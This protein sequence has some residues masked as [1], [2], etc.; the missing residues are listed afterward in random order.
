MTVQGAA[1]NGDL[2]A[3]FEEPSISFPTV[4]KVN[5][6]FSGG[7]ATGTYTHS[8]PAYGVISDEPS[9]Y[10]FRL[11]H[12]G[13]SALTLKSVSLVEESTLPPEVRTAVKV[14][15]MQDPLGAVALSGE[16]LEAEVRLENATFKD[17]GVVRITDAG[18]EEISHVTI[19]P[20]GASSTAATVELPDL[21]A[22][23]YQ[24]TGGV[25]SAQGRQIPYILSVVPGETGISVK[26]FIG[27]H[28]YSKDKRHMNTQALLGIH[29]ARCFEMPWYQVEETAA[30]YVFPV[31]VVDEYLAAGIEPMVLLNGSPK[32]ASSAPASVLNQSGRGWA[33][34]PPKNYNDWSNYVRRTALLLN[35][36]VKVYQI[37]NEPNGYFLVRNPNTTE[38]LPQIYTELVR[39]AYLEIKAIDPSAIVVA[40]G[41]AGT[42]FDF[43]QQCFQGGLLNY[44]DVISFHSYG[45]AALAG[46]GAGVYADIV[47]QYKDL[48]Q[49]Y[50]VIKPIWDCE[51]G[52]TIPE[53]TAGTSKAMTLL[54]G[55][56]AREAGGIGRYYL[57][58]GSIRRSPAEPNFQMLNAFANRSLPSAPMVAAYDRILGKASFA[59][60]VG[61][62]QNGIL[63]YRYVSPNGQPAYAGWQNTESE[64][65]NYLLGVNALVATYNEF[66]NLLEVT[67]SDHLELLR[68]VRF[69]KVDDS[70]GVDSDGDG[71]PDF[72]ERIYFGNLARTGANDP[73]GDGLDNANEYARGTKPGQRDSDGDGMS[74]YL[75]ATWGFGPNGFDPHERM[76]MLGNA[77]P[78][79]YTGFEAIEGYTFGGI[80]GRNGWEGSSAARVASVGFNS[81]QSMQLSG[82]DQS[83][84]RYRYQYFG[85]DS[86]S[87]VYVSFSAKLHSGALPDPS[88]LQ[89]P[90]SGI[91]KTNPQG[92]LCAYDGMEQSW[93]TSTYWMPDDV[94]RYFEITLDCS[95]RVWRLRCEGQDVFTNLGF[96][97]AWL[98]SFSRLRFLQNANA[99]AGSAFVDSLRV[100]ALPTG[101]SG[102]VGQ[103]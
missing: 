50:G 90:S 5:L 59:E 67:D 69:F 92:M 71:L 6:N 30:S 44:C 16:S 98:D 28:L 57:Y 34:Y 102:I 60:E 46:Q 64:A 47:N 83:H 66:G 94:W 7:V 17:G 68:G 40:G 39:R 21:A 26:K 12:R 23:W 61:N 58:S 31:N 53:G 22:G 25:P 86:E 73:D 52:F 38:T 20:L 14:I 85:A 1:A 18:G 76:E 55:I 91:F 89:S 78:Q 95:T 56:I 97:D 35:G 62:P 43:F 51:S 2:N 96:K 27:T 77:I 93:A 41:T 48:M 4:S 81:G 3:W 19:Q 54:Q 10:F 80:E 24:I 65:Q 36:K 103:L 79:W 49:P 82:S 84:I 32:W 9:K 11:E 8:V 101:K 100:S 74:D 13:N 70:G 75:E 29:A 15:G 63:L 72:W 33:K 37:W 45:Q 42:A 88:D 87:L 99:G